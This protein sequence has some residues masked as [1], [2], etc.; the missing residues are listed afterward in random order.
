MLVFIT[1]NRANKTEQENNARNAALL[2]DIKKHGFKYYEVLGC[3]QD[4]VLDFE[5]DLFLNHT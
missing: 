1:A 4:P 3:Y 2:I 5:A